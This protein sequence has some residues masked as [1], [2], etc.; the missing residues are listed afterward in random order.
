LY[1][2]ISVADEANRETAFSWLKN[3][4]LWGAVSPK[5][6]DFLEN[7]DPS[8][9]EIIAASWRVESLSTLLWA[10]GK[11]ERSELPRE[12]C[13]TELVQNIMSQAENSCATFVNEAELRSPSEILDE[14]DLIYRIHWAVVDSLEQCA[15]TWRI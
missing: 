8:Q 15:D 2:V 10:L 11:I 13:D 4:G 14:T 1:F 7:E 12:L 9:E 6:K 3:E 5:E